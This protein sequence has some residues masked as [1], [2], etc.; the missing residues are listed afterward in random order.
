VNNAG[1][2]NGWAPPS[3]DTI[4]TVGATYEVNVFGAIKTTQAF[5]PLIKKSSAPRIVMTSSSLGSLAWAANFDAPMA[6]VICSATTALNR[7]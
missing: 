4:A 2:S 3:E 7:R 1:I 5:L 6:E